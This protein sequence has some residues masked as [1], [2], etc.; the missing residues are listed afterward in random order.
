MATHQSSEPLPSTVGD[1]SS[2]R[3]AGC[4]CG[5]LAAREAPA[6]GPRACL[7]AARRGRGR[8]GCG[9]RGRG[10][11]TGGRRRSPRWVPLLPP[12]CDT[13]IPRQAAE[14]L[15]LRALACRD[16]M[17][18][19]P[20]AV[21]R[22]PAGLRLVRAAGGGGARV[23]GLAAETT[24]GKDEALRSA[25][26]G[27]VGQPRGVF[28]ARGPGA[29][30]CELGLPPSPPSCIPTPACAGIP[31]GT[32]E[33]RSL[34]ACPLERTADGGLRGSP[35]TKQAPGLLSSSKERWGTPLP[36]PQVT[37]RGAQFRRRA[38][39]SATPGVISC[40][41]LPLSPGTPLR[42]DPKPSGGHK[43]CCGARSRA[44]G[45]R[46]SLDAPP[47]LRLE[48]ALRMSEAAH[49]PRP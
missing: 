4:G 39:P 31:P 25:K 35:R 37:G 22:V 13:L 40:G 44:E 34:V 1:G 29:L 49:A 42:V 2:Q 14:Q 8:R 45:G 48:L 20:C 12:S 47:W 24:P 38:G 6:L 10:A 26:S 32:H 15:F 27:R 41:R 7:W 5:G 19:R 23:E 17:H 16:P 43:A 46:G 18:L 9:G 21:P 28:H 36:R 11:R 33:L 30:S 3:A